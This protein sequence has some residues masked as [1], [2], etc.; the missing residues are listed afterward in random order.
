MKMFFLFALM[1]IPQGLFAAEYDPLAVRSTEDVKTYLLEVN[2]PK[3]NR[4]IPIKVFL[5]EVEQPAAVVLYSH[6]LGGSRETASYLGQH[7]AKRGF[8]LINMQHPGSDESVW[9]GIPIRQ[10]M[11]AMKKAANSQNFLDRTQD[12]K[13]VLDQLEK[14]NAEQGHLLNGKLN[15]EAVGMSGHS[16]GAVTTEAVSGQAL[17]GGAQPFTDQRI[18]AAIAMSPSTPVGQSAEVSFRKVS[19]PWMLMTGTHD[20][21]P[22]GGQTMETRLA[23]FPALPTTNDRYQI[24]LHNAVHSAF[25]ENSRR[26]DRNRKNPNH[27]K[28]ILALSTAFWE[29]YLNDNEAAK[30]W[31]LSPQAREVMEQDDQWEALSAGNVTD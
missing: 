13:V 23:V 16:F 15:L 7:W 1:L 12:V 8:V 18:L 9:K 17:P 19:I 29:A 14:W 20:E 22:V 26:R 30:Q 24:I 11:P 27:H 4:E 5:P 21:A 3:R 28:V 25:T 6:G 2:D 31:L 10:I